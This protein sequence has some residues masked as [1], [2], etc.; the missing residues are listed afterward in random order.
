VGVLLFCYFAILGRD[1][2]LKIKIPQAYA[3]GIFIGTIIANDL[4]VYKSSYFNRLGV[5]SASKTNIIFVGKTFGII[6]R[7]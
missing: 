1:I 3:Y 5:P 6:V 7:F 4:S 2:K